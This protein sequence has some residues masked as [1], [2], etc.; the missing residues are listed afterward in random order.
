MLPYKD[1]LETEMYDEKPGNESNGNGL[2][3]INI[4]MLSK[5][6]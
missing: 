6:R 4:G 1:A 5:C 2:R 3:I